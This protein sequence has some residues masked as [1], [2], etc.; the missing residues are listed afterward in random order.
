MV[1][2]FGKG[3]TGIKTVDMQKKNELPQKFEK[4]GKTSKLGKATDF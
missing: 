4:N 1:S 2:D 3:K